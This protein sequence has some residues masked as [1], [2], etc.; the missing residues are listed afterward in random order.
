MRNFKIMYQQNDSTHKTA[1]KEL[2]GVKVLTII[3]LSYAENA[4]TNTD[5][6]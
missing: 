4:L 2:F 3:P 6:N 1:L 5:L